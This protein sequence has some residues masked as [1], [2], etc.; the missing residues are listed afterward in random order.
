MHHMYLEIHFYI[1]HLGKSGQIF[2]L[3]SLI[4]LELYP[5]YMYLRK[6]IRLQNDSNWNII[7]H[8]RS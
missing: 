1:L 6:M 4:S 8:V 7:S 2:I 3:V 5:L